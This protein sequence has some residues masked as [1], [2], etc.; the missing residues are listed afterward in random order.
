[1]GG[2]MENRFKIL[3]IM[4]LVLTGYLSKKTIYADDGWEANLTVTISTADN[5]LSFGQRADATD[6][7]DG[8]Y[9]VPAMLSGDIKAYFLAEKGGYWR[10]IKS[11][12]QAGKKRW[13]IRVESPLKG[14][15]VFVKW[16]PGNLMAV[17][18]INLIDGSTGVITDMK[19]VKSYSY[20]NDGIRD[21]LI[22]VRP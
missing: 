12:T 4:L 6:G 8:K 19:V 11:L 13:D 17:N 22:E 3:I 14:K 10:D 21:F 18:V 16:N 15:T 9:D 2:Q 20:Q 5:K 1:M 7:I